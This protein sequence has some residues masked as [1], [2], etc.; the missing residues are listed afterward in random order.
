MIIHG[1]NVH[2]VLTF[3]DGIKWLAR[4]KHSLDVSPP[5]HVQKQEKISEAATVQVLHQAGVRVSRVW[6]RPDSEHGELPLW[7]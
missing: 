1:G 2:I 6:L 3:D 5:L 7:T 4:I